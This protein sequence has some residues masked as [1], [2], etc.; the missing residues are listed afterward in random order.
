MH[1]TSGLGRRPWRVA[2]RPT[3]GFPMLV[4][5]GSCAF[6]GFL[7]QGAHGGLDITLRALAA[8]VMSLAFIGVPIAA[9]RSARARLTWFGLVLVG[10]AGIALVGQWA[11]VY[12]GVFLVVSA[13]ALLP[14]W[15]AV[16]VSGLTG[17]VMVVIAVRTNDAVLLTLGLV[18]FMT[19]VAMSV[20]AEQGRQQRALHRV[21]QRNAVLAVAAERTRIGRDLHDILGH[22]LTAIA[23]KGELA[24]RLI[25][26]NPDAARAQLDE[27]VAVARQALADT[28]AT[29][30]GLREVRVVGE[31]ASAR[32][33][34]EAA[35]IEARTTTG[36]PVLDDSVAELFGY[37]V[38]EGV[39][40]V[41]RHAGA[42]RCWI[43]VSEQGV[44]VSDDGRG[45][46]P[47]ADAD[48]T[49]SGIAGLAARAEEMGFAVTL[50][51][52][53]D[54]TVLRCARGLDEGQAVR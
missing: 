35:G 7:F 4:F 6:L 40:N 18:A 50:T 15:P 17:A 8:V 26:K 52:E 42:T 13:A 47:R 34:L 5:V 44:L 38:R 31:L 27:L 32:S 19:G 11:A 51:R 9:G 49:S 20:G 33:V 16:A 10:L 48:G 23:V 28:R 39:T 1:A 22:S 41:V 14:M 12:Y 2:L 36:V 54:R 25:D 45:P 46:A 29:A 30:S 3:E 24:Q 43:E 21:E 37:V 53:G